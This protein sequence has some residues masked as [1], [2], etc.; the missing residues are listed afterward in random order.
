MKKKITFLLIGFLFTLAV[1]AQ[2]MT[3]TEKRDY[4]K[5]T[6]TSRRKADE[7]SLPKEVKDSHNKNYN[8]VVIR[9]VYVYPTYYWDNQAQYYDFHGDLDTIESYDKEY[10]APEYYELVYIRDNDTYSSVYSKSGKHMHTRRAIKDSELP[11]AVSKAFRKTM[12]KDWE[13]VGEK[14]EITKK[15]PDK[16]IYR[17]KVKKGNETHVLLYDQNGKT[18]Q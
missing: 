2:Q 15:D 17:I 3:N 7:S 11:P 16:T 8:T 18:V 9:E 10:F 14:E 13:V 1:E 6:S 4:S 5:K 12:F